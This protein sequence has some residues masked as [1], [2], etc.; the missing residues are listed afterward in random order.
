MLAKD[1]VAIQAQ[2]TGYLKSRD[3]REG[4]LVEAG[5]VLYVI[6]SSKYKAG[7]ARA[8]ADL[9]GAV[10]NQANAARNEKRGKELLPRGAISASEMDNLTA[11]KLG[12]RC[13]HRF[14]TS[15]SD[16]R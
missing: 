4:E 5:D 6:D 12:R 2:V 14:S 15:P 3:F 9:A 11:K 16:Q 7:L 13:S 1:D 8:K 10:A